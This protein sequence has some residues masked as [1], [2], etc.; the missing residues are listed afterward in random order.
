MAIFFTHK[1]CIYDFSCAAMESELVKAYPQFGSLLSRIK[2]K[3]S[4]EGASQN[5]QKAF[6]QVKH[7]FRFLKL[8]FIHCIRD[9]QRKML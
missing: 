3:L 5:V 9:L 2:E 8:K 4:E 7:S 1:L 6:D